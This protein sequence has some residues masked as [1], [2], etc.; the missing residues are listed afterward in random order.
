Q[1]E[2][3]FKYPQRKIRRDSEGYIVKDIAFEEKGYK[4]DEKRI[5]SRELDS[6]GSVIYSSD[7]YS[8]NVSDD[9]YR[10]EDYSENVG[11]NYKRQYQSQIYSN[12]NNNG[13]DE[14]EEDNLPIGL[15]IA[16]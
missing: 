1:D 2:G 8:D 15:M 16:R 9:E 4:Y 5:D 11:T 10:D 7:D 3:E 12:N 14:D 6:N 13:E